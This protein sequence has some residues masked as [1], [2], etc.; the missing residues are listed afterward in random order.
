MLVEEQDSSSIRR[1]SQEEVSKHFKLP[2]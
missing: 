2:K 1:L